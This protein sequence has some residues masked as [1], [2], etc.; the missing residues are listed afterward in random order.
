MA[1]AEIRAVGKQ[2]YHLAALDFVELIEARVHRVVQARLVAEV[3]MLELGN[4]AVA[5][6]GE[7][8]GEFD[9]VVE[10]PEGRFVVR[11]KAQ[12]E[13]FGAGVEILQAVGHADAGVEHHHDGERAHF[14]VEDGDLLRAA[15]VD[16]SR[17]R[18][19]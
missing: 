8:R 11:Q 19:A 16:E 1:A 18:R 13:L 2:Q 5:V 15:V 7:P 4:Q 6:A 12:Q 14:V 9:L 17:S 10:C 3:E